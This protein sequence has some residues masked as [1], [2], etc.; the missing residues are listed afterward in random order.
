[1]AHKVNAAGCNGGAGESGANN[2]QDS[3]KSDI[4]GAHLLPHHA[5]LL[6]ASAISADVATARGYRSVETKADLERLGFAR[7][8]R[9]AP[10]L[11]VP[12]FNALGELSTYQLR[13]DEP[14]VNRAGRA[15][16]Y[17]T[18]TGSR[19]VL[20]VPPGAREWLRDPAR[21]LLITEGSKKADAA[22][23]K[24]LCCV[25]LMGVWGW[26]G[27]NDKGGKTAL[28]DWEYITV[29]DRIVYIAFDSDV[30]TKREVYT[31]L[32]RFK[33]FLD[34]RGARVQIIYFAPGE[35]S[36]KVGLDDFLREHST[37]ELL[38]L[39]RPD[40]LPPAVNDA[41]A[42]T[43]E[44]EA[45]YKL[46]R[47]L[48]EA[49]DLLERIE[50][51]IRARGYA[52]DLT[53]PMLVY[54]ALTSRV[55][56]RPSNLAVI[57]P[58]AAGK[59]FTVDAPCALM[60]DSA[61]HLERAGSP[62]A[63]IY[64]DE[65]FEHRIVIVAEADSIPDKGPAASAIRSLATDNAMSYDVVERDEETG[66]HETRHIEKQGPT[67]LLTTSTKRLR[68][69]LSTR[70]LTVGIPDS[71]DHVREVLLALAEAVNGF[72]P[73]VDVAP[74]Q[75]LQRWLELAGERR[76]TIPFANALALAVPADLIRMNRDFRQLLTMI[77]AVALLHQCQRQRDAEGRIVATIDDYRMVRERLL[78]VFT[79][80]ATGGVTPSVRATVAAVRSLYD[81]EHPV[82][83]KRVAD[84]L[85]LPKNTTLYRVR[86]ARTGGYIVNLETK[87]GQPAR[88]VP[89]DPLPEERPALPEPAALESVSAPDHPE[90]HRTVEP[91]PN[92]RSYGESGG[93]VQSPVE[94]ALNRA[95]EADRVN[96]G[97][98]PVKTPTEP[99]TSAISDTKMGPSSGVVQR[100]N[101]DRRDMRAHAP[102]CA[103]R[104]AGEADDLWV[105]GEATW[106]A[107]PRSCTCCTGPVKGEV[108]RDDGRCPTCHAGA[109]VPERG[110]HLVRFAQ[111]MG[112]EPAEAPA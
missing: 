93:A 38:T 59:N 45:A 103:H 1:M 36:A 84:H 6:K 101:G 111:D 79:A 8:Q 32:V 74:F 112:A 108:A 15:V 83:V 47:P 55:L 77:Q 56:E 42:V 34:Q 21:P 53:P 68:E 29:K 44:A 24:K 37:E 90:S 99:A 4:Y 63:L 12:V 16:K 61:Y 87:R 33:A 14:R 107:D 22:V 91:G 94:P 19:L 76:V 60:P 11:L 62:R 67:G 71:P 26:R 39:A 28:A 20:D 85:H 75:A 46:A 2:S 80:T 82:T 66:R 18:P 96:L 31:A 7:A 54:F 106:G 100:F 95:H 72:G 69:Q 23:S 65:D 104:P 48:L 40:L 3:S 49:P 50:G 102:I 64:S 41:E 51:T 97:S 89:G 92:A 109:R 110:G 30:M 17:E 105:M 58:S 98:I 9:N 86:A 10:G 27:S 52:G 73:V 70:M 25:A 5:E 78:D 13:P 57:A 35:G 88:L 81:E 43:A